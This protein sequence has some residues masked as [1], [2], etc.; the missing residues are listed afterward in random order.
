ME[1]PTQMMQQ[2]QKKQTADIRGSADD[3]GSESVTTPAGTFMGEHYCMKDGSGETW[4]SQQVS[5]HGVIKFQGKTRPWCWRR[6]SPM[7]KD[8]ITGTPQPVQSG[9]DDAAS[10]RNRQ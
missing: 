1:M 3:L 7:P 4:I 5:P 9:G 6:W 10:R 2:A 8:K